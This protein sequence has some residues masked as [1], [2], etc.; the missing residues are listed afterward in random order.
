MNLNGNYIDA[1]IDTLI[2][3][4]N[5]LKTTGKLNCMKSCADSTS[6]I[7]YLINKYY[8]TLWYDAN[9]YP[10]SIEIH[11]KKHSTLAGKIFDSEIIAGS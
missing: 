7:T 2:E 3:I 4:D 1:I 9:N 10:Y 8:V 11:L 6:R 5:F